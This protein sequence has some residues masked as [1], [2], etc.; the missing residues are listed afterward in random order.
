VAKENIMENK[1]S[2]KPGYFR[3]TE[4]FSYMIIMLLIF[5]VIGFGKT[6]LS[7]PDSYEIRYEAA[8]G[9]A[10]DG[11]PLSAT[12]GQKIYRLYKD[13]EFYGDVDINRYDLRDENGNTDLKYCLLMDEASTLS[14]VLLIGLMIFIVSR[15]AA[16]ISEGSTPFTHRN[17]RFIRIIGTLQFALAIVPGLV[18]MIMSFFRFMYYSST[19]TINS[20]FMF[21]VAFA[22][23]TLAQ[24]FDYGVK[25]QEDMDS[26]A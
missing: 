4:I 17:V 7:N 23:M 24:V 15:M 10:E 19:F 21:V 12:D 11:S 1:K 25:L 5:Q 14:S 9:T 2:K 22:V 18:R 13:G 6:L 3:F 26:I 8:M 16:E 20:F